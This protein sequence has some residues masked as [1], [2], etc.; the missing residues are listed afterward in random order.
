MDYPLW[1][2]VTHCDTLW[3]IVT[4]CDILWHIVTYCD[5]LW[6]WGSKFRLTISLQ[7]SWSEISK[8]F[9]WTKSGMRNVQLRPVRHDLSHCQPS[10]YLHPHSCHC[11]TS[12]GQWP[13]GEGR[14]ITLA[15]LAQLCS[16]SSCLA[17]TNGH[18]LLNCHE[19]T[20]AHNCTNEPFSIFFSS[21]LRYRFVQEWRI[22]KCYK[23]WWFIM[24]CCIKL[25]VFRCPTVSPISGQT[26]SGF[27]PTRP[28]FEKL[29][30]CFGQA[31]PQTGT[32]A[33]RTGHDR[34]ENN[35]R[36]TFIVFIWKKWKTVFEIPAICWHFSHWPIHFPTLGISSTSHPFWFGG[37]ARCIK[38]L[39]SPE[40]L[41]R[42]LEFIQVE[43]PKAKAKGLSSGGHVRIWWILYNLWVPYDSVYFWD[44]SCW[45]CTTS[46]FALESIQSQAMQ[47]SCFII[48]PS[49]S[50]RWVSTCSCCSCCS[51]CSFCSCCSC[52]S[53]K[54]K[55]QNICSLKLAR[56]PTFEALTITSASG[57][58]RSSTTQQPSNQ[59]NG[60]ISPKSIPNSQ[61]QKQL[62]NTQWVKYVYCPALLT[63]E[64]GRTRRNHSTNT[65]WKPAFPK[66]FAILWPKFP[67]LERRFFPKEL[68]SA[69]LF[70][71]ST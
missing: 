6:H 5:T 53:S 15:A 10:Q 3:H 8:G 38:P 31:F 17:T 54:K 23:F 59:P 64:V 39:A 51:C 30:L 61:K 26:I 52:T 56:R 45:Y 36:T 55:R 41:C 40:R 16:T 19:R 65:L 18:A 66:V 2:I 69:S 29:R 70:T 12:H 48:L 11:S 4:Y 21:C 67:K 32:W 34:T 68:L 35:H 46:I 71:S 1:H 42:W 14:M 28:R 7:S 22:H 43:T 57:Q 13:K 25:A 63:L 62:P 58:R 60:K 33:R 50:T 47:N 27:P 44:K 9:A 37:C 20:E 24:I 49:A